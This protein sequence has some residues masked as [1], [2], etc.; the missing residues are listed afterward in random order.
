MNRIA[1]LLFGITLAW[2]SAAYAQ[3][4]IVDDI[5]RV[6]YDLLQE[7]SVVLHILKTPNDDGT[8]RL[9][10]QLRVGNTHIDLDVR[11]ISRYKGPSEHRLTGLTNKEVSESG[12]EYQFSYAFNAAGKI[13][14]VGVAHHPNRPLLLT[15]L[16]ES[17]RQGEADCFSLRERDAIVHMTALERNSSGRLTGG[18]SRIIWS[19]DR[20]LQIKVQNM[21][22][23]YPT[24]I[25]ATL[26]FE[27]H[28]EPWAFP[29]AGY[30]LERLP[31]GKKLLRVCRSFKD[32]RCVTTR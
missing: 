5:L 6:N 25:I 1:A 22:F 15:P 19:T 9:A 26:V 11:T 32:D 16:A 24:D 13:I 2:S 17:C 10:S 29:V 30:E 12:Y 31:D 20:G 4:D 3:Q 23:E 14:D 8:E 28:G 7:K 21:R 27:G 18:T